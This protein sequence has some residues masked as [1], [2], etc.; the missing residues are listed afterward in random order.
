MKPTNS[1]DIRV[2][3]KKYISEGRK[4]SHTHTWMQILNPSTAAKL[5]IIKL[6][7]LFAAL[8]NIY[9]SD[10]TKI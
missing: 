8:V 1:K 4:P 3:T 7:N 10:D 2:K 5:V 9:L 6:Q